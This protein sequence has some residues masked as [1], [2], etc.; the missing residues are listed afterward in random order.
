MLSEAKWERIAAALA[1]KVD[2]PGNSD[3]DNRLSIEA[4]LWIARMGATWRDLPKASGLRRVLASGGG[5]RRRVFK[6]LCDDPGFQY[7][8]IE[9]TLARVHQHGTGSK[10]GLGSASELALNVVSAIQLGYRNGNVICQESFAV[11]L[12][13]GTVGCS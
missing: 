11:A 3:R 2:D 9:G 5:R 7:V 13:E 8:L 12:T 10:E 4:V 1:G 6:A